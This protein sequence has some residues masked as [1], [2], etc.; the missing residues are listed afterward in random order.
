MDLYKETY[1]IFNNILE[2]CKTMVDAFYFAE[3]IIQLDSSYKEL[4][5]GM[6]YNKKYERILDLRTMADTLR[7]LERVEYREEIDEFIDK[8]IKN[9]INSMQLNSFIKMGS[10][11][12]VKTHDNKEKKI[13]LT[14]FPKK[15]EDNPDIITK[16]CPHCSLQIKLSHDSNYI[17]CGYF[18]NKGYDWNGCGKD[19][20]AKCNKMLCKS[21]DKD[22]LFV[23]IN[24]VHDSKCC[25][26]FAENNSLNYEDQFCQCSTDYVK[27]DTNQ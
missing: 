7:Q 8:N 1:L 23:S 15:K 22:K 2:G 27:R 13:P 25:K 6:L 9:N 5:I 16:N 4:L 24:R 14:V 20:C 19:W 3:K 12:I 18:N 21:W 17:I 10:T 26:E 11:K